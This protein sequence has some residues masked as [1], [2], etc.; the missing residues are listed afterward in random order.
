MLVDDH[1]IVREGL[2]ALL[3]K[4]PDLNVVAEI[5]DGRTAVKMARKLL[6]NVVIMDIAM[7][8]MNGLEA[9]RQIVAGASGVKVLALSMY[10]D[11][12]FVARA[13]NLGAVGY[14]LKECAFDELIHAIRVAAAN[15][16]YLSPRIAAL[17]VQDYVG[18]LQETDSSVWSVLSARERETLQLIAEGKTTKEIGSILRISAKTV[19]SHRRRIMVKLKVKSVAGLTKY[20]I[21]EGLTLP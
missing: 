6:P 2:S 9:I 4:E 10:S 15:Q 18:Q 14:L 20:A 11:R 3:Q 19:G 17:V 21:R 5:A 16:V 1:K 12:R 13:L 8:D 7:P